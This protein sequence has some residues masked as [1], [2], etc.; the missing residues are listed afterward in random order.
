VL[1]DRFGHDRPPVGRGIQIPIGLAEYGIPLPI[2]KS[3]G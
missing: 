3:T 1:L 2:V